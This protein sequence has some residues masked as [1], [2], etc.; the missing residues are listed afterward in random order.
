MNK[1]GVTRTILVHAKN[2][3]PNYSLTKYI[4]VLFFAI[5]TCQW[6]QYAS[7]TPILSYNQLRSKVS[8]TLQKAK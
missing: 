8:L 6:K 4:P 7:L 3:L 2:I 5:T 1:N